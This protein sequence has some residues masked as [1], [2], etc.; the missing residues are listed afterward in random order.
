MKTII[1]SDLHGSGG[2]IRALA[3][4]CHR[5]QPERLLL[6]GDLLRPGMDPAARSQLSTLLNSFSGQLLCVRGNCD[7]ETWQEDFNFPILED[8]RLLYQD[9][10]LVFLTHGHLYGEACP[11]S[12]LQQ[13][14]L[15][16]TGHT[17][18][19]KGAVHQ[20]FI[21]ANPGSL[22]EPRGGSLPSYLLWQGEELV[23]KTSEGTAYHSLLLP[24]KEA[25]PY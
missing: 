2:A 9:G 17:H 16:L 20:N 15:L 14:D 11:P 24:P 21:Y 4:L 3:E 5:E 10:R 22:G 13:G 23:W 12:L 7:L 25:M 6:L 1:V 18:V 19:P 8:K